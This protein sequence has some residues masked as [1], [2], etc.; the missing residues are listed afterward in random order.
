STQ[1]LV[2]PA[3]AGL[4]LQVAFVYWFSVLHKTGVDW[5]RD[6]TAVAHALSLTDL[7][8]P[9]AARVLA[10]DWLPPLLTRATVWIEILGPL[11]AFSPLWRTV[12]RTTAV[13]LMVTLHV[14]FALCLDIGMFAAISICGWL[15]FIP[16]AVWDRLAGRDPVSAGHYRSPMTRWVEGSLGTALLLLISLWNLD[17]FLSRVTVRSSEPVRRAAAAIRVEQR[18]SMFAP[19]VRRETSEWT[20]TGSD[21]AGQRKPAFVGHR[22]QRPAK[23]LRILQSPHNEQYR[24][25]MGAWLCRQD[26]ALK[27]VTLTRSTR[28]VRRGG[29]LGPASEELVWAGACANAR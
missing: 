6:A 28:R 2:T 1:P 21:T 4:L 5:N 17:P 10:I 9:L 19:S 25:V 12:S 22:R 18:W 3:G 20:I 8:R 11:V 7:A 16:G 15:P 13:A 26:P 14:G 23:W 24:P 27:S 29:G